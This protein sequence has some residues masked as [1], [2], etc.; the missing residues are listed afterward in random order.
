MSGTGRSS[1]A[2]DWEAERYAAR[3]LRTALLPG[4]SC[5]GSMLGT[6]LALLVLLI[7][8]AVAALAPSSSAA[9][10]ADGSALVLPDGRILLIDG[11]TAYPV[12]NPVSALLLAGRI[13]SAGDADLSGLQIGP[14]RGIPGALTVV[15]ARS[16]L[17]A[18][19][20]QLC[21]SSPGEHTLTFGA[22]PYLSPPTGDATAIT[23]GDS[24]WLVIDG[25][26]YAAPS[27]T[28]AATGVPAALAALLPSA[29]GPLPVS[30]SAPVPAPVAC[31]QSDLAAPFARPSAA[32]LDRSS[33]GPGVRNASTTVVMPRGSA[34]LANR[35]DGG[36]WLLVHTGELAPIADDAALGRLGYQ[37]A[38]AVELPSALI[39]LLS[40][41]PLLSIEAA[42]AALPA[43]AA[44]S[45]AG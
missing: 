40:P 12:L 44:P 14:P 5:P 6:V 32:A 36:Y 10:P 26:R 16:A 29:D 2:A 39:E 23:A 37:P 13:D 22:A 7:A 34:V 17:L 28:D 35:A 38:D 1:A 25:V 11:D 24:T 43:H 18:A 9:P 4:A 8:S 42:G 15:P 3:R 33:V 41:G 31:A 20:W 27:A 19:A 21:A 45:S 30:A